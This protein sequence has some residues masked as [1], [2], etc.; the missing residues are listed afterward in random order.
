MDISEV[1]IG[2]QIIYVNYKRML[3]GMEY[4]IT[5]INSTWLLVQDKSNSTFIISDIDL[6]VY[7]DMNNVKNKLPELFI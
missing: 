3:L 7:E 2:Q 6:S 4:T 5:E 1:K